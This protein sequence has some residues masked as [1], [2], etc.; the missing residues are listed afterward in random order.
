MS[1]NT[2]PE[3]AKEKVNLQG[4]EDTLLTTLFAKARDAESATPILGDVHARP[5]LDRCD[6]DLPAVVDLRRRVI[7]PPGEGD[8]EL[9]G[10][11]A[12]DAGGH[13]RG[14]V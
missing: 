2:A 1:S 9:L 4:V 12:R 10:C 5:V 6:V 3:P 13:V 8:Y 11:D 14:A 7:Q